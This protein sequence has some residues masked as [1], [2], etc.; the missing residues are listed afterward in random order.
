MGLRAQQQGR[1]QGRS[2][3]LGVKF[4]A[5]H[6]RQGQAGRQQG[7]LSIL[8]LPSCELT[9]LFSPAH[10]P[11]KAPPAYLAPRACYPA[12]CFNSLPS[13]FPLLIL[14]CSLLSKNN[15]TVPLARRPYVTYMVREAGRQGRGQ[16][17]FP[18]CVLE[19][20]H[21]GRSTN[22]SRSR[23]SRTSASLYA[24]YG[25]WCCIVRCS[26]L[27]TKPPIRKK[28]PSS[29]IHP[30]YLPHCLPPPN[31]F[32]PQLH[33]RTHSTPPHPSAHPHPWPHEPPPPCAGVF[34]ICGASRCLWPA[35]AG[36]APRAQA[37]GKCMRPSRQASH[38]GS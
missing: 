15:N 10:L 18:C 25:V 23:S 12:H 2:G 27:P 20:K 5:L 22:R 14:P 6:G 3:L 38:A 35:S 21:L 28:C 33:P 13:L 4:R 36:P 37:T 34:R 9:P 30:A 32:A 8:T 24:L 7:A 26:A 17:F 1:V 16:L 29:S 19:W 11:P 31:A